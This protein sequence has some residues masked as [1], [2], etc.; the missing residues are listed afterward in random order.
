LRP[1]PHN[2]NGWDLIDNA[3][4]RPHPAAFQ[5]QPT[6]FSETIL[7][8]VEHLLAGHVQLL[9]ANVQIEPQMF[10]NGRHHHSDLRHLMLR[11]EAHTKIEIGVLASSVGHAVLADEDEGGKKDRLDG[12][13]DAENGEI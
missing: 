2:R 9:W 1:A 8:L 10:C 6:L 4:A 7:D 13:R 5:K 11:E 3:T 12:S